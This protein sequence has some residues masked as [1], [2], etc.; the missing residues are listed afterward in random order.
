ML[1]DGGKGSARRKEDVSKINENWDKIFGRKEETKMELDDD[2]CFGDEHYED[3][4]EHECS[5]CGGCGEGD[6]DGASC[7]RCHGS[8]IEPNPDKDDD[9]NEI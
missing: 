3:D 2:E 1:S 9:Y 6:Y 4:E 8:G 5:W 7:R